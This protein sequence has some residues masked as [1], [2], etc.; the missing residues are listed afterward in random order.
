MPGVDALAPKGPANKPI[1][2]VQDGKVHRVLGDG[3]VMLLLPDF[4]DGRYEYGPAPWPAG[5]SQGTSVSD[6]GSHSHG[7]PV[8][9]V[10]IWCAVQFVGGDADMPR[11]LAAY[12]GWE[13]TDG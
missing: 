9:T 12:P 5:T 13:P 6:H 7:L 3:T 2:G 4:D 1:D 8:A 11:V 10:G